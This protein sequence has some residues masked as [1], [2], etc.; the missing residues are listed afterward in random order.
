V[1]HLLLAGGVGIL[2]G[3][4]NLVFF[5]CAESLKLLALRREGDLA[6]IA[7]ALSVWER[8]LIPVVGGLL[9]GLVLCA[10]SRLV[11]SIGSSYFLEAVVAG[12]GRLPLRNG[13]INACSSLISIS[14]GASIGREGLLTQI[15]ATLASAWGQIRGWP[16]YRLRLLVACGA[17]A[18]LA[19]A[20]NAPLAGA[21][22]AAQ[23]VLGNFSMN[24]FAPVVFASVTAAV[25]SRSF[26]GIEPWYVVPGFNFSQLSQL[27]WFVVLGLLSGIMA[28]SF[29]KL[30]LL[31]KRLFQRIPVNLC[32]RLALGGIGVGAIAMFCPQVW[33]NGYSITNDLLQKPVPLGF[34]MGLLVA[35]LMATVISVGSG[36][37]GGVFTP[38]LFLGAALGSA[39]GMALHGMG[40]ADTLPTGVFAFTGMGS[41]L[42][43]TT[44]SPLLAMIMVF[45][46]SLNYTMMPPLMLA[47]ALGALVA[48]QLH[49]GSVYTDSLRD[50]QVITNRERGDIGAATRQTVG[51]IMR[52]P[53]H[54]LLITDPVRVMASRFLG[55]THNYLPVVDTHSRLEGLVALHDLKEHL[56]AGSEL[57]SVIAFDV[58]RPAPAILTPGQHLIDVLPALLA[59]DQ[60]NIPVVNN[61]ED[62]R[63]VGSL[64]RSE[65]LGV[66][67]EAIAARTVVST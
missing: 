1:V 45:E 42:A 29:L 5:L 57:D 33:G 11:R 51:E 13:L 37:V 61:L 41:V 27:P 10:G 38:T 20:Y 50:Q 44:H 63:L 58:M 64:V 18:G 21:V 62:R 17:A 46:L 43:A 54:P 2:G 47:C 67:S 66:L 14:S 28:A 12:D 25:L 35:K 60:R 65:A 19:A 34:L 22:F 23:I 7:G 36:A 59:S 39:V 30:L 56:N 40:Y 16:P 4:A 53:V 32:L 48:R 52:E 15:T 31:S 3:V 24:L 55:C 8:W 9:A 26:F 49:P 6:E